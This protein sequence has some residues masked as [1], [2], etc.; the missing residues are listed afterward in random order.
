MKPEKGTISGL[1][2]ALMLYPAVIATAFLTLPTIT[3]QYAG[4]D[5][6]LTPILSGISGALTLFLA[7]RLHRLYPGQ[8]IIEYSVKIVGI[9]PGKIIGFAYF[10]Y[11]LYLTGVIARQYAEFVKSAIMFKTPLLVILSSIL[12]LAAIAARGG[13]ELIAR[14]ATILTPVF[15]I[16]SFVLLLLLPDL[17][18]QHLFPVLEKG[19]IPVLKG[20][21]APN[22]YTSEFFLMTFFLP[23][24]SNPEK[25]AK[26][27][28]I[29]IA[30][31]LISGLY[32]SLLVLFLL[33]PDTAD[34]VYP[35]LTAFRYISLANFF[36][37]LEALLVAMW[38]IG[39]F[40]KLSVFLYAASASLVQTLELKE[41][42]MVVYPLAVWCLLFSLWDNPDLPS[43]GNH[44]K[45]TS[46][47]ELL[48]FFN[49]IPL[50]L[51]LA[52]SARQVLKGSPN[53]PAKGKNAV[54]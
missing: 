29:S 26:W 44:I 41:Y 37:N 40:L 48:A 31:D 21:L 17:N 16:P 52:A 38:I 28:A 30:A 36:E 12:L 51:L 32:A 7:V 25:G 33:G 46:P 19:W 47:F 2:M 15:V 10:I 9:V 13:V 24:L 4:N 20:S 53:P 35:V 1:Q 8:T 50:L 22:A 49:G 42:R 14:A 11:L 54:E 43:L 3:A 23:L 34:K 5:L 39:N 6:W 45:Y 27:A 18:V